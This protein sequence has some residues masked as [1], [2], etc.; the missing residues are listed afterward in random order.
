LFHIVAIPLQVK[1]KCKLFLNAKIGRSSS[2]A[3]AP[4]ERPIRQ[5]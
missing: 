5:V 2:T 3:S 4:R 1:K